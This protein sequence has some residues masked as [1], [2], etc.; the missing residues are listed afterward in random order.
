M[1]TLSINT[2]D[3]TKISKRIKSLKYH[4]FILKDPVK[5]PAK[6]TA[7]KTTSN[8]KQDAWKKENRALLFVDESG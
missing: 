6:S 7:L 5:H 2:I 1:E 8:R 4:S 3:N